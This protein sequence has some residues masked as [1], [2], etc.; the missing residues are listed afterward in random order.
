MKVQ[1]DCMD[2]YAAHA[3][4][5]LT[6]G[7]KCCT[8]NISQLDESK[9]AVE[10]YSR[11][12]PL[13]V[14]PQPSVVAETG[15]VPSCNSQSSSSEVSSACFLSEAELAL[16]HGVCP[17]VRERLEAR[18]TEAIADFS[19]FADRLASAKPGWALNS[20]KEP[21][22]DDDST[23]AALMFSSLRLGSADETTKG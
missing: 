18:F 23:D 21:R 9:V 22:A 14:F 5:T 17:L 3:L 12:G 19:E 10:L 1:V 7:G 2:L 16:V 11:R 6:M 20:S 8:A 15:E 4:M 13:E